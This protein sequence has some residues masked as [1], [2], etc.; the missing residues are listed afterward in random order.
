MKKY[1]IEA[2]YEIEVEANTHVEAIKKAQ[3]KFDEETHY[4]DEF[5]YT[6]MNIEK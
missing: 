3:L 5:T 2:S 4:G 6:D 1:I